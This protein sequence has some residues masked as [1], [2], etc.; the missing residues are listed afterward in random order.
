MLKAL[1]PDDINTVAAAY[2]L[3][4]Q[5]RRM[6]IEYELLALAHHEQDLPRKVAHTLLLATERDKNAA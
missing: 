5:Q 1:Q 6:D 3:K 4:P 2:K